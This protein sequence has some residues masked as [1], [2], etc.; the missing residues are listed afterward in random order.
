MKLLVI[1]DKARV[2]KYLPALEVV[3]QVQRV[4]VARATPD[5]AILATAADADFIMADAISPVSAQLIGGMAGLRLIH[6][7]GV[8]Y[9]AIDLAAARERGI[10]VCNCK[11]V[12]AGAVAE[13]TIL[14]MLACL[15]D[16]VNGDAAVRQGRQ[17]EAKER[18]MVEGIRELG[19]CKVGLIGAGDIARATIKRLAPWGCG[20]A[21]YKRT[22]L[23][24]EEERRL[25]AR[26]EPL[27]ELLASSDIVSLHVP[28]TDE[29]RGMVDERFLAAMKPG[30]IL[31]NTARGE[32]VDQEAL[33][34]AL[35]S[36]HLAAAGLDTL[37]PEP[38]APDHILLRLPAETSRCVVF[39]P[40][41]GG[42]TEGTFYRA[43][44]TVWQNIARIIDGTAPCNIVS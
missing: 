30:S 23:T 5:E 31:I 39:S 6:S 18:R 24:A 29:T 44:R 27:G 16:S 10:P 26:F 35:V 9:N 25:G 34:A 19:D 3:R 20:L 28:V 38:V 15:R 21:Y 14:L 36:G 37:A 33:A 42:I 41:I 8:A 7:E 11:G 32:V 43:H 1:G 2:E 40:H 12:N 17:I 22:P 4:V 13:Q